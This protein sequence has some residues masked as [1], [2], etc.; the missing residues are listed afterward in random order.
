MGYGKQP[1]GILE[2]GM[3]LKNAI[4]LAAIFGIALAAPSHAGTKPKKA[5]GVYCE[6]GGNNVS[7]PIS[8]FKPKERKGMRVGQKAKINIAGVGPVNCRVY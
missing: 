7:F 6:Q 8:R 3:K 2:L 5:S 4:A 1:F